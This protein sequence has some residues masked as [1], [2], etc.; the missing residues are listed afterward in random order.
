MT[1]WEQLTWKGE[2]NTSVK[3][4]CYV[5]VEVTMWN[6]YHLVGMTDMSKGVIAF[7]ESSTYSSVSVKATSHSFR[8]LREKRRQT[9]VMSK[10]QHLVSVSTIP[11]RCHQCCVQLFRFQTSSG[12]DRWERQKEIIWEWLDAWPMKFCPGFLSE[13]HLVPFLNR[14]N[15]RHGKEFL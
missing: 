14:W 9:T 4:I 7:I 10:W 13:R 1:R 15:Q 8:G 2:S 3:L 6:W 11:Q 5:E 12:V